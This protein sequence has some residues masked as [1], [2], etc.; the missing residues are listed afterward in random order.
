MSFVAPPLNEDE[1]LASLRDLGILDTPPDE[2]FD[3]VTRL[4]CRLFRMPV[5]LVS[6]VDEDRNGVKSVVCFPQGAQGPRE[7]AFCAHGILSP[8]HTLVVEDMTCDARFAAHPLVTG[9]EAVRFYAGVPLLDPQGRALGTLCVLDTRPRRFSRDDIET[10]SELATGVA[11]FIGLHRATLALRESRDSYRSIVELTRQIPWVAD[12]AGDTVSVD[13]RRPLMSGQTPADALGRG[14][15]KALH[16]DDQ[17]SSLR[18]WRAALASGSPYSAEF[19]LQGADGTYRWFRSR[20][21]PQRAEDGTILRWR[22]TVEDIHESRLLELAL[23]ESEEHHRYSIE[24]SPQIP[25]TADP[26]GHVQEVS[27]RLSAITGIG[28]DAIMTDGWAQFTHPADQPD[29]WNR[30]AQCARSGNPFDVEYRIRIAGGSYRWFHVRAFARRAGSGA[31]LRWYGTAE[32]ISGRKGDQAQIVHMATHDSLTGLANRILYRQRIQE[33]LARTARGAQL[34]ILCID[35][36]NFKAINDTRGHPAG[37]MLLR[38]VAQR[39]TACVRETDLVAR[40]AGDEF[41]V[42][43]AGLGQPLIAQALA[44]RILDA[45]GAPY[46]LEGQ[47]VTLT[48]TI[49][50]A[51]APQDGT[52]A[53]RLFQNA[54]MALCRAKAEDR[55]SVRFFEPG[56]HERLRARQALKLDLRHA[57][58][59]G[60]MEVFYQPLVD[61]RHERIVG[62]EALLRWHHPALGMVP[63]ATFIPLAEETGLIRRLG[64]WVL[65][66]AC[67]EAMRWSPDIR[68]AVNL[69]PAQFRSADLVHRVQAV[70]L[71]SGLQPHRLELEIT[72]SVLLEDSDA[73]IVMLKSMHALGLKIAMD[74]F[75]TGYSSLC[76]LH[77]FPFDKLK[78]DRSFIEKFAEAQESR[79]IVRAVLGLSRD[80]GLRS[81]AEGIET[82]DQF[83]QLRAYGCNEAQGYYFSPPVPTNDIAALL[84]R[85]N[86]AAPQGTTSRP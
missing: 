81:V 53:D 11:D 36:D 16:P 65:D 38:L 79:A 1:R 48:A 41:M 12:P 42:I 77:R 15:S 3:A 49:G 40:F 8:E 66:Q 83:E 5:A 26:S 6:L 7:Q 21:A 62:F 32:D 9:P 86:T 34:A 61:I 46:D 17:S 78:I 72:E 24:A 63:P 2:R 39:L 67:R 82:A 25:W 64:E 58:D 29:V 57:L 70:L 28:H 69:S 19:R 14:W 55:G 60:E 50:V 47:P 54:D 85:F 74:D 80:L 30:W 44:T 43:Q 59:R 84:E 22:G 33:E 31:I 13:G 20:A 51:L 56:M 52:S 35:L 71:S 75:G 45:L 73:N 37:D 76:Y 18:L 23:R 4:A 10:L 68:V 27:A